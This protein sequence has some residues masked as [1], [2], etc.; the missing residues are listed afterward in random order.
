[1]DLKDLGLIYGGTDK[2]PMD[3]RKWSTRWKHQVDN[4]TQKL[5]L[6]LDVIGNVE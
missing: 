6:E 3:G 1:M 4:T 5:D 2:L